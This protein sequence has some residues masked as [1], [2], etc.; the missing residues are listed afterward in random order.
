[1]V[2]AAHR[3]VTVLAVASLLAHFLTVEDKP[4]LLIVLSLAAVVIPVGTMVLKRMK[5]LSFAITA[6]LV[7]VP[8]LAI[9]LFAGHLGKGEGN[10]NG[11]GE[12]SY[13][14]DNESGED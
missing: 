6:K 1:M 12:S 14:S 4:L 8:L 13:E 5:K 7:L 2:A 10:E 9:G 11:R 3:I